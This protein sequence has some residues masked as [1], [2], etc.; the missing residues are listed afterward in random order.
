[1]LGLSLDC[2]Q[3]VVKHSAYRK[4][5]VSLQ[6][7]HNISRKK[8]ASLDLPQELKFFPAFA[9]GKFL[10]AATMVMSY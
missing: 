8:C 9:N 2:F 5:L 3:T 6:L 1:M 10:A 7:R 4:Q